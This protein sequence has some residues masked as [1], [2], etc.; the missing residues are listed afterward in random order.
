MNIETN[1]INVESR[2]KFNW[3]LFAILLI[4]VSIGLIA[5][6]PYGLTVSNQPISN[7]A[8]LGLI[9]QFFGQLL[10]YSFLIWAGLKLGQKVGLGVPW[11]ESWT[12][13]Q[14]SEISTRRVISPIVIGIAAGI[15]M[16]IFDV[17]LFA[18]RL[19]AELQ[20]A[21]ETVRPPAWQ[22]FLASFHGG[23]VE[24]VMMRLFFLTLLAWSAANCGG[25]RANRARLSCG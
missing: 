24:E 1:M 21:G 2:L 23:I 5:L 12:K 8:L 4:L 11:L 9:P 18:P 15:G 19:A 7:V 25:P 3:R 6:I 13:G 14:S 16:I 20:L 17:Y 10:L 22:G